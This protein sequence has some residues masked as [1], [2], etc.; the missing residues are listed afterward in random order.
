LQVKK[1]GRFLNFH[2]GSCSPKWTLESSKG[3]CRGQNS[4]DWSVFYIIGKLLKFRC[5]KWARL[6]HL[7]T[8]NINYGQKKGWELNWQFDFR[9][10]KVKNRLDFHA[11]RWHVT[12]HSKAFDEGYNFACD[13]IVIGGLETKL[14]A[15]KVMGVSTLGISRLPLGSPRT[16]CHLDVGPV[17][18]HKVYY[19]GEGGGFP[20]VRAMVSLMS[21]NLPMAHPSTKNV[22][23][24][25]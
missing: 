25:H 18:S 4:L 9:P 11:C 10:L 19:M 23:A 12:Y 2:F 20:Q 24:M 5:L 13:F 15:P 6:T 22:L 21:S 16:K 3:H 14:W 8:C 17:A 7:G 1:L